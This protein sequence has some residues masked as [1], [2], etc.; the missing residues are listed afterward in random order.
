MQRDVCESKEDS[1]NTKKG[2]PNGQQIQTQP[3]TI[4]EE[5]CEDGSM[6]PDTTQP[7]ILEAAAA[8]R[9]TIQQPQDS[10][11][12]TIATKQI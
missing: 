9:K 5:R 12:H 7:K 1:H 11:I 8:V 6:G 2:S 4:S 10:Q 3:T